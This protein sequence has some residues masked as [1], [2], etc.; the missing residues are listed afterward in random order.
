MINNIFDV[1]IVRDA[2]AYSWLF[3][4]LGYIFLNTAYIMST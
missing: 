4:S 3:A 1:G 2:R